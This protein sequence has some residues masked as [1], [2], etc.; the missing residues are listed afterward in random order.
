[1]SVAGVAFTHEN[2][3]MLLYLSKP[4]GGLALLLELLSQ[5]LTALTQPPSASSRITFA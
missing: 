1:M 2:F 4:V 5:A 3:A